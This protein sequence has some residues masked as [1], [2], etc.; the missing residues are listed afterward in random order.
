MA[1]CNFGSRFHCMRPSAFPVSTSHTILL[2]MTDACFINRDVVAIGPAGAKVANCWVAP[3]VEVDGMTFAE[4]VAGN[5]NFRKF[6]NGNCDMFKRVMAA[7]LVAV[8]EAIL[9]VHG[10]RDDPE[11]E[12]V[13]PNKPKSELLADVP[14]VVNAKVAKYDGTIHTCK[15]LKAL[16]G[17]ETLK[18]ELTAANLQVLSDTPNDE[19]PVVWQPEIDELNVKWNKT[20]HEV[21]V[22]YF[23]G[24]KRRMKRAHVADGS[25]EDV[26][27]EAAKAARVLQ[28][29]HSQYHVEDGDEQGEG[30]E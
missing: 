9:V 24:K 7:R 14:E 20:K 1:M 4:V 21:Q 30:D 15:V 29:Y 17:K 16:H 19:A 25:N 5:Y 23:D 28:E 3:T 11:G 18:F 26:Q 13:L 12:L 6:V 10:A 2:I 22:N 27:A 8:D